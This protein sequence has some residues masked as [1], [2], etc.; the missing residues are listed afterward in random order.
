LQIITV[1][2]V[3]ARRIQ[4]SDPEWE[5]GIQSKWAYK[6]K[7][8]EFGEFLMKKFTWNHPKVLTMNLEEFFVS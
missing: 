1:D 4:Q 3:H 7:R 2:T 5:L 8:D 6:T